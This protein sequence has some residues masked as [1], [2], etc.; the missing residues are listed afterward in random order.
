MTN[1]SRVEGKKDP[2]SSGDFCGTAGQVIRVIIVFIEV[3]FKLYFKDM[4]VIGVNEKN[5]SL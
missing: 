1:V 3:L 5:K 4:Y 2:N